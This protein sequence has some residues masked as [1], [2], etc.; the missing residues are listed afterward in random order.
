MPSL[1]PPAGLE[2][3]LVVTRPRNGQ[4]NAGMPAAAAGPG[5]SAVASAAGAAI[6][7]EATGCSAG[8][9][10]CSVAGLP[11]T[12]VVGATGASEAVLA[13]A[14]VRA[15]TLSFMP[16]L[17]GVSDV[18]LLA[19]ASSRIVIRFFRAIED[20]VSPDATTCSPGITG[21]VGAAATAAGAGGWRGIAA[22]AS[23]AD[24]PSAV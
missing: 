5:S 14:P 13:A 8:L 22:W 2:P 12:T 21:A 4:R 19:V 24:P 6:R 11:V 20:S 16:T 1:A 3:K 18:M 9:I 17:S 10:D 15:G 7:A 23:F